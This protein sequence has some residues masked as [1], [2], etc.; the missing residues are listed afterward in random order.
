MFR[1]YLEFIDFYFFV[2]ISKGSLQSFIVQIM[3]IIY[4]NFIS[5]GH[6]N[7]CFVDKIVLRAFYLRLELFG[8]Q[9]INVLKNNRK[10][11]HMRILFRTFISSQYS[12]AF[13]LPRM[14]YLKKRTFPCR[15]VQRRRGKKSFQTF[16][17]LWRTLKTSPFRALFF[18]PAPSLSSRLLRESS[19]SFGRL[20]RLIP[21]RIRV[22]KLYVCAKTMETAPVP[23]NATCQM[24]RNT[25]PILIRERHFKSVDVWI[26]NDFFSVFNVCL[27][28]WTC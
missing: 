13:S 28:F 23:Y 4:V 25:R 5:M 14:C 17:F 1:I 6:L 11:I 15:V 3:F 22:L 18:I 26:L 10:W 20:P 7:M 12:F 24:S 16:T 19:R 27:W 2:R 8:H 21:W 9:K